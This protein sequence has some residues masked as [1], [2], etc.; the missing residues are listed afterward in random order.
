MNEY[1]IWLMVVA[2]LVAAA[3][4]WGAVNLS[5]VL[6][7]GMV[8]CCLVDLQMGGGELRGLK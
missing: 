6:V 4:A 1:G 3:V 2:E 8:N 7:G 5:V